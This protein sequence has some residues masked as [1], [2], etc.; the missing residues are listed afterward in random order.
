MK[1][2]I[3]IRTENFQEMTNHDSKTSTIP[4]RI[5]KRKFT[6]KHIP[7]EMQNTINKEKM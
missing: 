3:E 7:G 6:L 2:I 5:N 4:R 1:A